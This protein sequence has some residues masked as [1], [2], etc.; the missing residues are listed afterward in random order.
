MVNDT[1]CF[2]C[3]SILWICWTNFG[4]LINLFSYSC[5]DF[6]IALLMNII[7]VILKLEN[8]ETH[9]RQDMYTTEH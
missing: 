6:L 4:P 7:T 1:S 9:T 5:V 2:T 8:A 3:V